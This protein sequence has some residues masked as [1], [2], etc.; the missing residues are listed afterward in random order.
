MHFFDFL[1]YHIYILYSAYRKKGAEPIS[2]GVIGGFQASNILTVII[3]VQIN[4]V[5][6]AYINKL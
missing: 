4:N 3:L 2:T 5:R 6:E 1:Y